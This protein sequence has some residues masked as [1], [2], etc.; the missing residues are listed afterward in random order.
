MAIALSLRMEFLQW[1]KPNPEL[2]FLEVITHWCGEVLG[3]DL[4]GFR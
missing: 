4:E 1:L 3:K 2:G